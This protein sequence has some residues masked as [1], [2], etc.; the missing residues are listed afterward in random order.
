[1]GGQAHQ[2][3]PPGPL[4]RG[5][6]QAQWGWRGHWRRGASIQTGMETVVIIV[7]TKIF[8]PS[9]TFKAVLGSQVFLEGA[10]AV[11]SIYREPEPVETL[12]NG[13]QEPGAETF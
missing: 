11:K 9:K 1:M 12:K 13:S 2:P 4:R 10:G 5:L 3:P 6:T 7:W 8:S